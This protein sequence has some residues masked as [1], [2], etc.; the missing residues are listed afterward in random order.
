[1]I[2]CSSGSMTRVSV[3][4]AGFPGCISL[5]FLITFF[6]CLSPAH[7]S[8]AR[9]PGKDFRPN[10]PACYPVAFGGRSTESLGSAVR[11]CAVDTVSASTKEPVWTISELKDVLTVEAGG[12]IAV[13]TQW[14]RSKNARAAML[15]ALLFPGL[16]QLYNERPVKAMIAMGVETL[17]L[18]QILIEYRNA[19]REERIRDQFPRGSSQW[20]SHDLWVGEYKERSIDWV[21]WSA[22]AIVIL[23]LDAYID[24]HLHDMNV[25]LEGGAVGDGAGV[26]LVV[27]F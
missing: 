9:Q 3:S 11:P 12:G 4:G 6:G 7:A 25:R 15:C 16:G 26:S 8:P 5:F 27:G 19:E 20:K 13:G 21:W 2:A 22:G 14:Q 23:V 18:S 24:A 10:S 1:M 17:Y